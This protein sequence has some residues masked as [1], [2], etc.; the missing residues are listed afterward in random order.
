VNVV[1][2]EVCI[3]CAEVERLAPF[4]MQALG[5]E[6]DPSEPRAL[7]D[8][9]GVGPPLWFQHVPEPKSVKNRTHLDVYFADQ[10]AAERRRDELVRIGGVAVAEHIDFWL[11]QDPEGNEFCLCWT[12]PAAA[13][14]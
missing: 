6:R 5:Y 4:W 9:D 8:P 14:G 7:V 12:I 2:V 10:P 13:A 1:R 3:D 11:M